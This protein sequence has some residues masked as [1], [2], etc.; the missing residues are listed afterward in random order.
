VWPKTKVAKQNEQSS[1]CHHHQD[2]E[3]Q[4]KSKQHSNAPER[5]RD[6]GDCPTHTDAIALL[7]S[8]GK[9]PTVVHQ[10]V[11]PVVAALPEAVYSSFDGGAAKFAEGRSFRSPPKRA[12]IS[13]YRI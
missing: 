9:T 7:S 11:Q 6:S 5:H 13:V 4:S 3:E 12:V 1:H 2:S 10:G 8:A